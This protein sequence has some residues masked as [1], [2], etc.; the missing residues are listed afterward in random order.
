MPYWSIMLFHI[1]YVILTRLYM[2]FA[3]WHQTPGCFTGTTLYLTHWIF[4]CQC[5]KMTKSFSHTQYWSESIEVKISILCTFI[6]L[7]CNIQLISWFQIT[8]NVTVE[9]F[10]SFLQWTATFSIKLFQEA[11]KELTIMMFADWSW[12][13]QTKIMYVSYK[14]KRT[15]PGSS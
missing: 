10:A 12:L 15:T 9:I 4:W 5:S 3:L 6:I 1:N 14:R 11:N 2:L 7:C 8:S 13:S